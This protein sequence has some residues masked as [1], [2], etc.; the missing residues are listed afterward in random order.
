[1]AVAR[2]GFEGAIQELAQS[3]RDN[4]QDNALADQLLLQWEQSAP[5]FNRAVTMRAQELGDHAPLFQWIQDFLKQTAE[6]YGTIIYS[7]PIVK[8]IITLNFSI[9]V[10]FAPKGAWQTDGLSDATDERIEYRKHFIPFANLVTYYVALYGCNYAVQR[11]GQPEL[12][13][14]CKPAAEKLQFAM[15][16]YIAPIVSDWIFKAANRDLEIGSD[17][18]HYNTSDDLAREIQH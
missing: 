5:S 17:R 9:P 7:L 4:Q 16:R 1:M 3:L 13:K 15:G 8:N 6:K 12:K 14:I 18:L 10:V 11:M 2:Q